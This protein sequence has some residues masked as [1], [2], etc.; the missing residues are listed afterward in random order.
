MGCSYKYASSSEKGLP[1]YTHSTGKGSTVG[2]ANYERYF[3]RYGP[4]SPEGNNVADLLIGQ[5]RMSIFFK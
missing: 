1:Y 2:Q 5:D 3:H 4:L